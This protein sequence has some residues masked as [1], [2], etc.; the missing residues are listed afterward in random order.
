MGR[1]LDD[2][3]AKEA[4][5]FGVMS[6]YR[7]WS[8]WCAHLDGGGYQVKHVAARR[9]RLSHEQVVMPLCE[10]YSRA[11]FEV[12]LAL[13]YDRCDTHVDHEVL[14]QIVD[15]FGLAMADE[16]FVACEKVGPV[17][18]RTLEGNAMKRIVASVGEVP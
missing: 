10:V 5:P 15:A 8:H 9:E 2:S 12:A 18:K 14:L 6:C 17:V 16:V 4:H 1:W 11:V 13:E 3:E 7:A